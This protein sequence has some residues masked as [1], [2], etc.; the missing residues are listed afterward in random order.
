MERIS[1]AGA[2][3][4]I[5]AAYKYADIFALSSR[6]EVFPMVLCEAMSSGL[7]AAAFD[8]PAAAALVKN[9]TDGILVEGGNTEAFAAALSGLMTDGKR[10]EAL[11][12]NAA[13]ITQRAGL[14]QFAEAYNFLIEKVAEI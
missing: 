9:G 10:R 7:P 12:K 1:L 2:C 4:D 5:G 11:C 8:I 6:S 3:A 13:E 14:E